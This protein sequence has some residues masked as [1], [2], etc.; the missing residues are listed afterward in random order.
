V[1]RRLTSVCLAVRPRCTDS[2]RPPRHVLP[3]VYSLLQ[4]PPLWSLRHPRRHRQAR[5]PFSLLYRTERC[6]LGAPDDVRC[7][8]A[9]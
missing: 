8:G 7:I 3:G 9:V 6:L 5:W 2:R 1:R 4:R